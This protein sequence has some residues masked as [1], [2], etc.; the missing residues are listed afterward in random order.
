VGTFVA[1]V[2]VQL[3]VP[4]APTGLSSAAAAVPAASPPAPGAI[5]LHVQAARSVNSGPGFI[6]KGDAVTTYKWLINVDDTG[7]PGTAANPL[8]TSCLPAT[9]G[10]GVGSTDP[11]YADTCPWP[12]VRNT[13]GQAPIV[14]Q[15]TESDLSDA[16]PL[17]SLPG[18]KYLISVTADGFKIAG[19]HFRVDGGSQPV[20]VE[21]DPTPLPLTTLR[22]AVFHDLRGGRRSRAAGL[23][24]APH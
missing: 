8:T 18:G 24:R 17:T 12:S 21:L 20:V 1:A 22:I 19:A 6:H 23:H 2:V 11:N 14:A 9:A 5:T 7:D 10:V 16:K 15:G 4:L 3:L 13:S